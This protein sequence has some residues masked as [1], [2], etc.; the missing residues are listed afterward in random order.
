MNRLD[1]KN[2]L[3]QNSS[4]CSPS[5]MFTAPESGYKKAEWDQ[6]KSVFVECGISF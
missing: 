2:I 3:V 5:H 6:F 4:L 1:T